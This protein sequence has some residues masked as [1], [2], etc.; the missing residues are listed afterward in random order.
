MRVASRR[1]RAALKT[2]APW[3]DSAD[4]LRIAPALRS[5]TRV[6]GAVRELDVVRGRLLALGDQAAS[7]GVVAIEFVVARLDRRRRR[8]RAKMLALFARV[9]M[10]RLD[11]LLRR[12]ADRLE[13]DGGQAADPAV[14]SNGDPAVDSPALADTLHRARFAASKLEGLSEALGP[15][16][17]ESRGSLLE[18]LRALHELE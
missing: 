4:L 1:L 7:D 8:A 5:L 13:R 17:G 10:D 11:E 18:F 15:S 12:L 16:L 14:D 6:L 3:I 2:F 9:D